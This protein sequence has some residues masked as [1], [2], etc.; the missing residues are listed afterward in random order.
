VVLEFDTDAPPTIALLRS[1]TQ[2]K[3][4]VEKERQPK[5]R[6]RLPL[7]KKTEPQHLGFSAFSWRALTLIRLTSNWSTDHEEPCR[8]TYSVFFSTLAA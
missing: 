5:T 4:A 7:K 3:D 2:C 8:N 6:K 1:G